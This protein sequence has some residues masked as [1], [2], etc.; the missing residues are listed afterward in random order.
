MKKFTNLI[1][2]FLL[3]FGSVHAQQ[4]KG[5]IGTNNWLY[6]WTEFKPNLERY[7][8]PTQIITGNITTDTKLSKRDIYLL[9]GNVFVTNKATLTIEPGTVILGDYK[10]NA[11]LTIAKGAKI[12]ADGL[13]TDPI[14]FTSNSSLKRSG[15]WGGIIIL[16]DAPTNKFGNGSVASYY[17]NLNKTDYVNTNYGG[18]NVQNDAGILKYVRIEFAGKRLKGGGNFNGILLACVGKKT[19]LENIMVS[20]SAG[21][22]LEVIG[23]EVFLSKIVSYRS[24][25][26][27]F[28]FNYGTQ[29]S[30]I[31]SLAV[32]SPY[33]SNSSGARCMQIVSYDKEEEVDFTK[34]E[35]NV[36]AKNITLINQSEN[37]NSD[38]EKGLVKESVYVAKNTNLEMNK[39]VISGFNPAVIFEEKIIVN[40]ESLKKIVFT[41]MYFNNCNGNIFVENNSNNEDLENWYGNSA[42]FNVYSKSYNS[43]TF[44]DLNNESRPDFRLRINKIIATNDL[45]P[46][47]RMD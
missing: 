25:S 26:N 36:V 39:S 41:D 34:P 7:G 14:V 21:N 9:I 38:I 6:G 29:S 12:I 44:I 45:D 31:N 42:F 23:G 15:D 20:Y 4:E 43:E 10:S 24:N 35:T 40:Q 22:S 32:R 47:L 1:W 16:G 33:I 46:D 19:V 37:L 13:E 3:I 11:S 17:S 27:D 30:L 28:K 18:D 8:E 5:I 2:V